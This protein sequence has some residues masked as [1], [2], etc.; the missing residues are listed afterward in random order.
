MPA[1][2]PVVYLVAGLSEARIAPGIARSPIA[3]AAVPVVGQPS[4][5]PG[6]YVTWLGIA[7]AVG[8]PAAST[9]TGI[10]SSLAGRT[11][12]QAD[13]ARAWKHVLGRVTSFADLEPAL[14]GRAEEPTTATQPRAQRRAG[15][16]GRSSWT[17][18]PGEAGTAPA[19]D[20][21]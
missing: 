7:R 5:R 3:C 9:K 8:P 19:R 11:G 18:R 20:P 16:V 13:I 2:V 17:S 4:T 10:A 6:R 15:E 1:G 12:D 14:L 21:R